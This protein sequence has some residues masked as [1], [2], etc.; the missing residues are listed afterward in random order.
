MCEVTIEHLPVKAANLQSCLNQEQITF[1]PLK[2]KPLISG[3]KADVI[4]HLLFLQVQISEFAEK[5]DELHLCFGD[6]CRLPIM[7]VW[8]FV[9]STADILLR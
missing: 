5:I 3:M 7:I 2:V 1:K 9:S 4:I 6:C 8:D